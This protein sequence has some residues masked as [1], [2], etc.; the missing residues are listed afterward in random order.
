MGATLAAAAQRLGLGGGDNARPRRG[1]RDL[2]ELQHP[3]RRDELVVERLRCRR[4]HRRRPGRQGDLQLLWRG[5]DRSH[6]GHLDVPRRRHA[7]LLGRLGLLRRQ[8]LPALPLL[9]ARRDQCR[10]HDDCPVGRRSRRPR[11]RR[12]GVDELGLGLDRHRLRDGPGQACLA[13]RHRLPR[14][15]HHRRLGGCRPRHRPS[16][17]RLDRRL[18]AVGRHV[19]VLAA[20]RGLPGRHRHRRV[21]SE[22]GLQHLIEPVR[23]IR[24]HRARQ[25]PVRAERLPGVHRLHLHR[26][27][28]LR[29]PDWHRLDL[30]RR[31]QRLA[32]HRRPVRRH[33]RH[34]LDGDLHAGHHREL[35]D[36]RRRRLPQRP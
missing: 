8:R 30:R 14:A 4:H 32:R 9:H 27:P 33:R 24:R 13:A 25:R 21:K 23:P 15:K 6:P 11:P 31:G 34:Q 35:R 12:V 20:D 22:L 1:V 19:A 28:R 26:R 10:R 3:A 5:G 2:P 7:C 16:H 36:A 17:L 18:G 29:R